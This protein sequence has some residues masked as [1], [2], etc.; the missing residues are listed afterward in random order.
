[1]SKTCCVKKCSNSTK[2]NENVKFYFLPKD[3]VRFK[4]WLNE[5]GRVY[6]DKDGDIDNYWSTI[7]DNYIGHPSRFVFMF[8]QSISSLV[9]LF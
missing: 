3:N 1:M 6:I 8:A 9:S 2:Y 5:I 7:L 4:L